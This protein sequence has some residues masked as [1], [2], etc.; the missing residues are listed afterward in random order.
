MADV[1]KQSLFWSGNPAFT[2]TDVGGTGGGETRT[3]TAAES[4]DAV[5][6]TYYGLSVG[7]DG[8]GSNGDLTATVSRAIQTAAAAGV[9][10]FLRIGVRARVT[11]NGGESATFQPRINGTDRGTLTGLSSTFTLYTQDFTTDPADALAWTNAKVNA[12]TFGLALE[13]FYNDAFTPGGANLRVAEYSIELWGPNA[14]IEAPA[15]TV[16]TAVVGAAVGVVGLVVAV[17][18]SVEATAVV[19]AAANVLGGLVEAPNSVGMEMTAA[20]VF[21]DQGYD[22]TTLVAKPAIVDGGSAPVVS[23]RSNT[24]P[25]YDQSTATKVLSSSPGTWPNS[26]TLTFNLGGIA[27]TSVDGTGAITGVKCFAMI[28]PRKNT[29]AVLNNFRFV[30]QTDNGV[31]SPQPTVGAMLPAVVDY[32]TVESPLFTTIGGS[33]IT[34]ATIMG[35]WANWA[36]KADYSVGGAFAGEFAQVEVAEAWVE[37]FGPLGV[38]PDYVEL[39]HAAGDASVT[40]GLTTAILST[41]PISTTITP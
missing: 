11:G 29:N 15:S 25:Y 10:S 12:Q 1:L 40:D 28:R 36:L 16:L 30:V 38:Q 9:I 4:H 41:Q 3:I 26:G 8:L 31:L 6:S 20:G 39:V 18:T 22:P 7:G 37:V 24:S 27:N 5:D 17:C 35:L 32:V 34:W 2:V 14:V 23:I 19:G 33:A 13:D 21:A